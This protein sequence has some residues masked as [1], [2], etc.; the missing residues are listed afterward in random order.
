M[1]RARGGSASPPQATRG[2]V[3]RHVTAPVVHISP[4]TLRKHHR[5]TLAEL[6][7]QGDLVWVDTGG[8]RF[9]VVNTP[10]LVRELLVVR[11]EELVKPDS[12][13]LETGPP[14]PAIA[15]DNIPVPEFR[16][17]L[18]KGMGAG[19]IPDVIESAT[20]AAAD[21][22]AQW[23]DGMRFR[24]MPRVR[25]LAIAATCRPSFG[26]RLSPAEVARTERAV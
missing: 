21:E 19:R 22:V 8:Q 23:R 10:D 11:A 6:A 24:L 17:A 3:A 26:S 18:A 14:A 20:S 9:L 1:S 2:P 13:A 4:R 16:A 12:Q 7:A 25:R 15:D 5:R